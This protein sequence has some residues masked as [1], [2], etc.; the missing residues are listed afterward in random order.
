MVNKTIQDTPILAQPGN[1]FEG[2][3]HRNLQCNL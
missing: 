3:I 2:V 1:I